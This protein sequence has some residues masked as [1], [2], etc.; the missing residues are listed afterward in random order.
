[1]QVSLVESG[2]L[3]VESLELR[4]ES[5]EK[6]EEKEENCVLGNKSRHRALL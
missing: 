5:E 3:R 1:M 4:V 6:K 2:E